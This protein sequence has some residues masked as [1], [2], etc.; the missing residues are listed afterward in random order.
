MKKMAVVLGLFAIVAAVF[1][2]TASSAGI[3]SSNTVCL[4]SHTVTYNEPL[5]SGFPVGLLGT[6]QYINAEAVYVVRL[7]TDAFHESHN[8]GIYTDRTGQHLIVAGACITPYVSGDSNNFACVHSASGGGDQGAPEVLP[9]SQLKTMKD[10]S[11][12]FAVAGAT[13]GNDHAGDYNL[14]CSIPNGMK[15]TGSFVDVNGDPA[16]NTGDA[17]EFEVVA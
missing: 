9:A 8:G 16:V 13:D 17:G 15:P 12:P 4:D 7:A 14:T 10:W 2:A 6:L 1:A 3:P 5:R 11:N